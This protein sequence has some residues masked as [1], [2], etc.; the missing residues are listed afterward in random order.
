ML[1][2]LLFSLYIT[3][4][5][6]LLAQSS[7]NFHFYADDTQLYISFSNHDSDQKLAHLSSILDKVYSWFC[8]NRLAVNP[9][10]TEYLLIGTPLQRS[11]ITNNSVNFQNLALSPSRS[12]KNLGVIF[13]ENLDFKSHISSVCRASFFQIRQIRQIRPSLTR[14]S[15]TI[16]ANS[17]VH[18]KL[19]Y[20]N[21]LLHGLPTSSLNRL[22][23]V[24]NSLARVVCK[25]SRLQFRSLS[26]LRSLHWLPVNQRIKYKIAL[27]TFKTLRFGKPSYL[28][29]ILLPYR[30]S[31]ALRST[32]ANLLSVPNILT[33]L[34]RRSFSY[35]A[36]TIWNSL[37]AN[38][39]SCFSLSTFSSKLKTYL[40][41]P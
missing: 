33:S 2:P 41:P 36:P 37:P 5:S 8:A 23:H 29:E 20:C 11:K 1:G 32:D 28:S 13:D 38:L 17:I 12:A 35:A 25:S 14:N 15:A 34:G 18:S 24:Q 21:S 26:L 30:P 39:R 9:S 16:L 6:Y 27:L 19:D 7:I 31:R 10:K 22:Q 4:L 40:F 3:P